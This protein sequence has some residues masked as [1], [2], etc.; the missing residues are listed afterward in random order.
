MSDES[1]A[2]EL[3]N[4]VLDYGIGGVG[5]LKN[6]SDLAQDYLRDASYAD[7]K[8]RIRSLIRWETSKNFT[9][10]FLTGL[11]GFITMPV[12]VPAGLG[13]AW[14]LQARMVGTIA[15]INGYDVTDDRVR[16][17]ALISIAGD[18]GKEIAKKAGIDLSQRAGKSALK[19]VPGKTLIEI[20]KKVGFRL[21][22]KSG[23][24]GVVNLSRGI[25][26]LGG[27]VGGTVDAASCRAVGA[28]ARHNFGSPPAA[29]V[30]LRP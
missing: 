22:T 8:A 14:V 4:K 23:S 12:S 30:S 15:V 24:T 28:V 2:L 10:G 16:T 27:G 11:G 13:A 7:N 18:G 25:P 1:K 26:L 9:T 29:S 3:V 17:L 21:L 20:N 19:R 5:P 6:S